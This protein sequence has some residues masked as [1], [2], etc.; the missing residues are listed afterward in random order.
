MLIKFCVLAT[1]KLNTI[2]QPAKIQDII[3]ITYFPFLQYLKKNLNWLASS[4]NRK[5]RGTI[6]I[7]KRLRANYPNKLNQPSVPQN[8]S[9]VTSPINSNLLLAVRRARLS[10]EKLNQSDLITLQPVIGNR[11]I[12]RLVNQVRTKNSPAES[13][14]SPKVGPVLQRQ[15]HGEERAYSQAQREHLEAREKANKWI[16]QGMQH[17]SDER[18][19]NSCEWIY[20]GYSKFRLLT[21]RHDSDEVVIETEKAKGGSLDQE[22]SNQ[23][24]M[25][26]T[27][28]FY[29]ATP[30][31]TRNGEGVTFNP[32]PSFYYYHGELNKNKW[33]QHTV[34]FDND[35]AGE[36]EPATNTLSMVSDDLGDSPQD[37]YE[38]LKHEVQHAAD[39]HRATNP[40]GTP[41]TSPKLP[42]CGGDS[43]VAVVKERFLNELKNNPKFE[44]VL[45]YLGFQRDKP[46][47]EYNLVDAQ[48]RLESINE[49]IK[50]YATKAKNIDE[51][52]KAIANILLAKAKSPFSNTPNFK[53]EESQAYSLGLETLLFSK[54]KEWQQDGLEKFRSELRAYSFQGQQ[55]TDYTTDESHAVNASSLGEEYGEKGIVMGLDNKPVTNQVTHNWKKSQWEIF[56]KLYTNSSYLVI[57]LGWDNDD[58]FNSPD[59]RHYQKQIVAFNKPL[60]INPKNSVRVQDFYVALKKVTPEM[61]RSDGSIRSLTG[62]AGNLSEKEGHEILNNP[63][64]SDLLR[65]NLGADSE[66]YDV[67]RQM[68]LGGNSYAKLQNDPYKE[69]SQNGSV[70]INYNP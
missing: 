59:Q 55:Y 62:L 25:N 42:S 4:E 52:A 43:Y 46:D 60:S 12:Q 17:P 48:E 35:A 51:A 68:L 13:R 10:P 19:K 65:K 16:R 14:L 64:M 27:A 1:F 21:P 63:V 5:I 37:F 58:K 38:T 8:Q 2:L 61:S 7:M 66:N 11:A 30:L 28:Y 39:D 3:I 20:E 26:K 22:K 29:S 56:K 49:L 9:E 54:V 67:I 47:G 18:L 32:V 40:D 15:L 45:E 31:F 36:L 24:I 41:G 57:K 34:V 70:S 53:L 23:L 33:S 50:E 44:I 69:L 6:S